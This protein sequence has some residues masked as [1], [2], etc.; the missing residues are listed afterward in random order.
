MKTIQEDIQKG[1]FHGAYLLVGE[2]AFLRRDAKRQLLKALLGEGLSPNLTKYV[3]KDVD[4][5]EVISTADTPSFFAT[6]RVLLL[7]DIEIPKGDIDTL[8]DYLKT[9]HEDSVFIFDMEALDKRGKLYKTLAKEGHVAVFDRKSEAELVTWTRKFFQSE[10]KSISAADAQ[11]LV[12]R[13]GNDMNLLRTEFEK[14]VTYAWDRPVITWEDVEAVSSVSLQD[15][16]FDMFRAMTSHQQEKALSLYYDL[17]A[18]KVPVVKI[19]VLMGRQYSQLLRAKEAKERR[20][21]GAELAKA[22]GVNSSYVAS[23]ITQVAQ[24]Y[25]VQELKQILREIVDTDEAIKTG[26]MEE[27]MGLELLIVRLSAGT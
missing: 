15:R 12:Q 6:Q 19:L 26:R 9:P 13:I 2:E 22:I 14:L 24:G 3:G 17:L 8:C 16:I 5:R 4:V 7:E 20:L 10:K 23:T 27:R 11:K 25:N 18:L 1:T 21:S